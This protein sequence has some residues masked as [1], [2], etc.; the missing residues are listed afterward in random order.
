MLLSTKLTYAKTPA[1]TKITTPRSDPS[2]IIMRE[3]RRF[4]L[5]RVGSA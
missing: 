1:T 3:G 4:R 5:C 2:V